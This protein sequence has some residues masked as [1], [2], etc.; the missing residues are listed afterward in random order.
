MQRDARHERSGYIAK[1]SPR[2]AL[3]EVLIQASLGRQSVDPLPA[4]LHEPVLQGRAICRTLAREGARVE[5]TAEAT[6]RAYSLIARLP[7]LPADY[8]PAA[9]VDLAQVAAKWDWPTSWPEPEGNRLEGE[10]VMHTLFEPVGYRDPLGSRKAG[11]V[12][13]LIEPRL[14]TANGRLVTFQRGVRVPVGQ[15][16]EWTG[17]RLEVLPLFWSSWQALFSYSH[18][19]E[20]PVRPTP[21]APAKKT[22]P[23]RISPAGRAARGGWWGVHASRTRAIPTGCDIG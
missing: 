2:D 3:A 4:L 20:A 12:K 15:G 1:R 5:D 21:M 8:G 13:H 11:N 22:L 23:W 6:M 10:E 9:P 16:D 7:N 17:T 14:V 18:A 19:A